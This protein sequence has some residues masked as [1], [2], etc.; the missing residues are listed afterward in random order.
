MHELLRSVLPTLTA[1]LHERDD[2]VGVIHLN[3][4]PGGDVVEL[5]PEDQVVATVS[6]VED[7]TSKPSAAIPPPAA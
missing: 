4:E 5:G 6:P 3:S 1:L 7:P 2:L